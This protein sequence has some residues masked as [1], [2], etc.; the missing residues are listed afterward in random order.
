MPL[1]TTRTS[2]T[3][4]RASSSARL[5][6][7]LSRSWQTTACSPC[8]WTSPTRLRSAHHRSR[9]STATSLAISILTRTSST[10]RVTPGAQRCT[11]KTLWLRVWTASQ[12]KYRPLHQQLLIAR[13]SLPWAAWACH[14]RPQKS[15]SRPPQRC[16]RPPAPPRTLHH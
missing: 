16:P 7:S 3:T 8:Q 1:A 13:A 10:S 11:T 5:P 6:M 4:T 15:T 14:S 12:T 9:A 2:Q